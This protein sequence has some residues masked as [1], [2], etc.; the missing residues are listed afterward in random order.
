MPLSS[1]P[2]FPKRRAAS[3]FG[4]MLCISGFATAASSKAKSA[5]QQ[6]RLTRGQLLCQH[7]QPAT[8]TRRARPPR[9]ALRSPAAPLRFLCAAAVAGISDG[10]AADSSACKNPEECIAQEFKKFQVVL[11]GILLV[12]GCCILA[13]CCCCCR[14]Q[15]VQS[16]DEASQPGLSRSRRS[17]PACYSSTRRYSFA[18][19][20]LT[21]LPPPPVAVVA[22]PV[23]DAVS[24]SMVPVVKAV[25]IKK[26][27]RKKSS[28]S[29]FSWFEEEEE[30]FVPNYQA[31]WGRE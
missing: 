10:A 12:I 1:A 5:L 14:D 6:Q 28:G 13:C 2:N 26:L 31:N 21:S 24:A 9:R 3:G 25:E 7:V 29:W 18:G 11:I 4:A 8:L 22:R 15:P 20:E 23:K 17:G 30:D 16:T 27:P 19:T